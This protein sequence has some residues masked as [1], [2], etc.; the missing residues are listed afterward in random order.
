[1]GE[2]LAVGIIHYPPL[3]GSDETMPSI[4]N[5]ICRIRAAR[6]VSERAG[7]AGSDACGTGQRQRHQ[8]CATF[9]AIGRC[10]RCA[11]RA[12]KSTRF[13]LDFILVWVTISTK[14]SART[15]SRLTASTRTNHSSSRR[16]R[17]TCERGERQEVPRR[18]A[19]SR[20]QKRPGRRVDQR[21]LRH[22]VLN[23]AAASSARSRVC[24]RRVVP[25]HD[26]KGFPYPIIPLD[27]LLRA[28]SD[29]AARRPACIR[30]SAVGSAARSSRAD[31]AQ[32]VRSRRRDCAHLCEQ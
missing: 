28:K 24:E 22:R 1:M 7:R 29:R 20:R 16:P 32:I 9:I 5:R 8:R 25:R 19:M 14:I 10:N 3:A 11:R 27:K 26:R 23:K 6:K 30:E 21:R 2:I 17:I 18:L 12:R 15:W 31:T 13:H 4:L